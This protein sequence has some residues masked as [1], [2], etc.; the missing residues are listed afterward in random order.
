MSGFA[1]GSVFQVGLPGVKSGLEACPDAERDCLFGGVVGLARFC[2]AAE[3][4][5]WDTLLDEACSVGACHLIISSTCL[6]LVHLD[7]QWHRL[8]RVV[9]ILCRCEAAS[10]LFKSSTTTVAV[11]AMRVGNRAKDFV[12]L[13]LVGGAVD[14]GQCMRLLGERTRG[15]VVRVGRL[16]VGVGR[17]RALSFQV[18]ALSV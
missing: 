10:F 2:G 18:G 7:H 17:A 6:T 9:V 16:E 8:L 3:G 12:F 13:G 4:R 5:D 11:L 14:V 1:F 15:R